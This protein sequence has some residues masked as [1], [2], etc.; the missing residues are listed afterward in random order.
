MNLA[1]SDIASQWQPGNRR[2]IGFFAFSASILI[3][4]ISFGV[5]VSSIKLPVKERA[6]HVEVPERIAKYIAKRARSLPPPKPEIQKPKQKKRD[7]NKIKKKRKVIDKPLSE[8]KKSARERVTDVGMLALSSDLSAISEASDFS[9]LEEIGELK[10][11]TNIPIKKQLSARILLDSIGKQVVKIDSNSISKVQMDTHIEKRNLATLS[12]STI[13]VTS[14][15]K[16]RIGGK[17]LAA[18]AISLEEE[19]NLVFEKINVSF[20]LFMS[21]REGK[22]QT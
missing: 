19:L 11:G 3:I 9:D 7:I 14:K 21:V 17:K 18:G 5:I 16:E 2:G 10:S 13:E 1:Y 22:M 8:A 4:F 20:I 12:D 15:N 6:V